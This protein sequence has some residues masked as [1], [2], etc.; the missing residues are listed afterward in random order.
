MHYGLEGALLHQLANCDVTTLQS[1]ILIDIY[2]DGLPLAKSSQ[3]SLWPILG[4]I[5]QP[6]FHT[7]FVVGAYHYYSKP[8]SAEEFLAPFVEEYI[9]LH[10]E[11]FYYDGR[12]Y[13]PSIR[14]VICDSP[15]RCFVTCTKQYNGYYGC[16]KCTTEGTYLRFV[17]FPELDA[18]LRTDESFKNRCQE[19]HHTGTSP[20]ERAP[21]NMVTQFPLDYMHVIL[22]GVMKKLLLMWSTVKGFF[23][24]FTRTK[25]S[26]RLMNLRSWMPRE[27]SR[28]PRGLEEVRMWKATEF[29]LFLLYVGPSVLRDILPE[30]Y[31]R[32]FTTLHCA[33]RILCDPV[34][35]IRN[36]STAKDLLVWF[37]R[38]FI[39]L[40]GA[41]RMVSNIHNLIHISDDV[42]LYGPLDSYSA[43][44]FE[45]FMQKLKR[46]LRSSTNPLQQLHRRLTEMLGFMKPLDQCQEG[47]V[48]VNSFN[49][50]LPL[51]CSRPHTAIRFPEFYL[52]TKQSDNCC[53]MKDGSIVVIEHIGYQNEQPVIL[54]RKFKQ[55]LGMPLYPF[56]SR[57]NDMYLASKQSNL[58]LW[59]ISDIT[60]KAVMFP[61][62][63]TQFS[64][65]PLLHGSDR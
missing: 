24:T 41:E 53:Y 11:G 36:N 43:F 65:M 61:F 47:Y 14:A 20:F 45:N 50:H 40:Y 3:S 1:E 39:P 23:S 8:S 34:D 63:K 13:I 57:L 10:N 21:L 22:L 28:K 4:R 26:K 6:G 46:L 19:E 25:V 59:F 30:K 18:P 31:L 51:G 33:C 56:D 48:L 44:P 42:K 17:T 27:F 12:K 55:L 29:R 7:P 52:S 58:R 62:N 5:V 9:Q 54:G 37:V 15:A 64:I 49:G 38:K 2:V 32:H 16:P 60:K 35:C